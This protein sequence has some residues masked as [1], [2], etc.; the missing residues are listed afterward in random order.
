M[1]MRT[2]EDWVTDLS[3]RELPVLR[4]TAEELGALS[5]YTDDLSAAQIAAIVH[6]D[7]LMTIKVLG[8]ANDMRRGHFSSDI[9]TVEHGVMMLGIDPFFRHFTRL[10]LLEHELAR[11]PAARDGLL[12]V[13][14]RSHHAAYHAWDWSVF[15]QDVR[16]DEVYTEALL[17]DLAELALWCLLPDLALEARSR[18]RRNRVPYLEIVRDLLGFDLHALGF[19]LAKAWH[20]PATIV[21]LLDHGSANHS[22][23]VRVVLA[24]AI[25][26]HAETGWYSAELFSEIKEAASVLHISADEATARIHINA[27]EAANHWEW[28]GVPPAAAWLPMLPGDWPEEEAGDDSGVAASKERDAMSEEVCLAPQ[29]AK[30][31]Q[32]MDEIDAHLDGT[33]TLPELMNLVLQ[34][35]HEGIGLT[36]VV[37][38]LLTADRTK[39]KAKYVHGAPPDSPLRGFEFDVMAPSLFARLMERMQGVW[40]NEANRKKLDPLIPSAIRAVIG[41]GDFYAM[42]VFVHGKAVAFFYADRGHGTCELDGHSYEAFKQLCLKAASGMAH[43]S[44]PGTQP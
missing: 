3:G 18:A 4:R 37:F 17:Y 22:R 27:V 39:V 33:F 32:V 40:Y 8:K 6:R 30:S 12:R 41:E 34:G 44:R 26:K 29:P 35:M 43:L 15:R 2:I 16:A 42:S 19:P 13:I 10:P 11:L 36:R 24:N 20:L 31:Q 21:E 7:P 5:G 14:S 1:P 38:G 28:Y 9:V 25:A 23:D